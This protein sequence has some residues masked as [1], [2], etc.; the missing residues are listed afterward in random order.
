MGLPPESVAELVEAVVLL[1]AR[2][3]EAD[4]D[5]KGRVAAG[6]AWVRLLLPAAHE[7]ARPLQRL[8]NG[9]LKLFDSF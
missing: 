3:W 2:L 5:A 9:A 7:C 1:F 6:V 4:T 8:P